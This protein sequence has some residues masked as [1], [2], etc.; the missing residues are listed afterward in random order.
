MSKEKAAAFAGA[1]GK[2]SKLT[3]SDGQPQWELRLSITS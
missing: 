2:P 3:A 1:Y